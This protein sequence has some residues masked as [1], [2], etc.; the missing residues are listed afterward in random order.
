[1]RLLAVVIK[2]SSIKVAKKHLKSI[3]KE[4]SL[5]VTNKTWSFDEDE[6][7]VCIQMADLFHQPTQTYDIVHDDKVTLIYSK[8]RMK[9]KDDIDKKK[10]DKA[11]EEL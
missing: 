6:N 5:D 4:L 10:I 3:Y 1:M 2:A 11:Y 8:E 9:I 7:E